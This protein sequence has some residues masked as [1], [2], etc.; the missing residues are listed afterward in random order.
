MQISHMS[1]RARKWAVV[2]ISAAFA[3]A[4]ATGCSDPDSHPSQMVKMRDQQMSQQ[5]QGMKGN[6]GAPPGQPGQ[7]TP[8]SGGQ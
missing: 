1:I 3:V 8:P 2:A 7:P 5:R 6:V 4:I